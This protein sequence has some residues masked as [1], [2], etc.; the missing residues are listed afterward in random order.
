MAEHEGKSKRG[1]EDASAV[2]PGRVFPREDETWPDA[3][4]GSVNAGL[5][6]EPDGDVDQTSDSGE[7]PTRPGDTWPE[8]KPGQRAP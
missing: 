8:P 1:E 7:T 4:E 3:D 2:R 6:P 5:V